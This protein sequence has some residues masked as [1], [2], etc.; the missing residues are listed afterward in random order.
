MTESSPNPTSAAEGHRPGDHR[1]DRL[2][3]VVGDRGRDQQPDPPAQYC[4]PSPRDAQPT[5][6][7]RTPL[8]RTA[9][10]RCCI[11]S[12]TAT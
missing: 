4:L 3:D 2:D 9:A 7:G 8:V 12:D 6:H 5:G 10:A 11:A 1:D